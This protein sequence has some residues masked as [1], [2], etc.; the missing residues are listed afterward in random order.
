MKIVGVI[1]EYNPFHLGHEW[2]LRTLRE[3]GTD[4]I[5]CAM[6]GNFVQRGEFAVVNKTA[7]AEMALRG[8][9]NLVLELPTPWACA[10]A[11]T[12]ALGGVQL[13]TMAGCTHLA[14]GC[15]CADIAPVQ[16]AAALL[17]QD[18]F[19]GEVKKHLRS[20]VSYAAAR[21]RAAAA[22]LGRRADLLDEPNNI[23][24]VEYLKAI[25]R[26]NSPLQ[27]IALPRIGASHDGAV[28]DGIASASRI[29][30]WL[31]GGRIAEA[32]RYLSASAA[33]ILRREIDAGRMADMALCERGILAHLRR[34]SEEEFLPYDGGNEGLYHRFY[35]AVQDSCTLEEVLQKAKTKRY[36]YARLRRM[37]LAAY[38]SL[39]PVPEQ[40]PY[41][42]LLAADETGRRLLRQMQ[43]AGA[44]VLTKPAD[45]GKLGGQAAALF[46]R[47][48]G[49][50]D[51]YTLAYTDL[52][53]SLCGSDW[54][55]T[56]VMG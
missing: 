34:K 36:A 35:Q 55:T 19:A 16:E 47:E 22:H 46:A 21:K 52:S 20:G 56:P 25:G 40:V 29:R 44:P 24:A 33:G 14:F 7:R 6:S 53:Q 9:A 3:Q 41:L 48:C 2:M 28:K 50:T 32:E 5:V 45:V 38:L 51:L 8:G 23:L 30:Q 11:E 17:A 54:R 10:T 13:L 37:A 39:P 15:E 43:K 26:R 31:R 1:C 4:A 42:R 18:A 12:F 27:P 49:M